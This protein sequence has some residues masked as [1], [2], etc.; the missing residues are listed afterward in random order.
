MAPTAAPGYA[1]SFATAK[2]APG[3]MVCHSP[4]GTAGFS[5]MAVSSSRAF[6]CCHADSGF[7]HALAREHRKYSSLAELFR[8]SK[9]QAPT[10]GGYASS[11]ATAKPVPA[12][13][14][15][16]GLGDYAETFATA[17]PA[18]AGGLGGAG[19]STDY[20]D[21]FATA[22]Q[23]P[24]TAAPS[25]S[26]DSFATAKVGVLLHVSMFRLRLRR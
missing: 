21:T 23:A 13:M 7:L 17:K 4:P 24:P 1:D 16:A 18:S 9:T 20:A 14:I 8:F 22:R 11:F 12:G 19:G 26:P 15:P 5:S 3:S 10:A 6:S 25:G 2:Q